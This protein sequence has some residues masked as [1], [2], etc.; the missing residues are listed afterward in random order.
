[1]TRVSVSLRSVATA[2]PDVRYA[3]DEASRLAQHVFSR[4]HSDIERLQGVFK[5]S[6][7][8]FRHSV[9]PPS[10]L[11]QPHGFEERTRLFREK[12]LTLAEKAA[13]LALERAQLQADE[14]DAL[15]FCSSTGVSV[16]G[17]DSFLF[18][19][20]GLRRTVRRL[21]IF[22]YGCA[23]G[24]LGLSR[25]AELSL[26][27]PGERVLF[28]VVE[29]CSLT[30]QP[31]DQSKSNIVA[32][33]LFAD[34]AAAAVLQSGGK[35]AAAANG[36]ALALTA[37]GERTWP[38]SHDIMGWH[39]ADDGFGVL[40]SPR[41]PQFLLQEFAP[42]VDSF[43]AEQTLTREALAGYVMHPGG[44]KVVG[45][46][47]ATLGLAD[48]AL[49]DSRAIL[50][51]YGNM[52]APTVLFVLERAVE[53]GMA[54]RHLMAAVGPGFTAGFMLLEGPAEAQRP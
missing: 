46:L 7:V 50:R 16:P 14:V 33:A 30:F 19:R 37:W 54:G 52:S 40:F 2:S 47:E 42:A 10:W 31:Q 4:D 48:G 51:E 11:L 25:A 43:L 38:Q 26:A 12:A 32:L 3:Q 6:G 41:I 8:G 44:A 36:D 45:A 49:E 39:A 27:R 23:G 28:V 17:I 1:M 13:L 24:V 53:G 34:G 35:N 15:V 29:L 20:L 18:D 5:N 9:V 21:Q 22:G